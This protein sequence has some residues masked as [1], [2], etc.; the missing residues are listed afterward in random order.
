MDRSDEIVLIR[1]PDQY[2][3]DRRHAYAAELSLSL[4]SN[5]I[6][7][8]VDLFLFHTRDYTL[9]KD[10]S[11]SFNSLQSTFDINLTEEGFFVSP[12]Y[13]PASEHDLRR[14]LIE[15]DSVELLINATSS[16]GTDGRSVSL[17][18]ADLWDS[19]SNGDTGEVS[20]SVEVCDCP[21]RYMGQFC[22]R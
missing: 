12:Q 14:I 15:L 2:L 6:P 11:S 18:M 19:V 9:V 13:L 22:E 5:F 17:F 4:S 3:G 16:Q 7:D 21:D 10:I 1:F 8:T 20:G